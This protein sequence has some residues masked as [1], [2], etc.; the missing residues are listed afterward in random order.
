MLQQLK[1]EIAEKLKVTEGAYVAG[2]S[3]RSSAKGAGIEE[4]DV[5]TA[6]N[7]VKVKN[8]GQLQEQISLY[9]PGDKVKVSVQRGNDKKVITVDLK[10][11]QGNT[12]LLKSSSA[13]ELLG[14]AFVPLKEAILK[15]YGIS[16]GIQVSGV[17]AGKFNDVGITKGYIIMLVNEQKITSPEEFDNIVDKILR[18]SSDDKVLF[19]KGFYPNGKTKYYAVDLNE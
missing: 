7:D 19:I 5:I 4:G 3:E 9:R 10:N 1:P 11:R 16:Y 8:V 13:A 12:N 6:V 15:Q 18:T 2:F 14:V 17:T